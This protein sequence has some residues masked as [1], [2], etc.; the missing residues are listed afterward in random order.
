MAD[1]WPIFMSISRRSFLKYLFIYLLDVGSKPFERSDA[2][3]LFV[4][5]KIISN[6]PKKRKTRL[7]K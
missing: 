6:G 1:R 7:R 3:G 4:I 2:L 5:V